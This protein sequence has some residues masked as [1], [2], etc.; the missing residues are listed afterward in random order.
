M[1]KRKSLLEKMRANPRGDWQIKDVETLCEQVG[2]ELRP[3]SGGS[4]FKVCS[5][6]LRDILT[7]PARRPIK[8]PYIRN[9]V[10]YS[11]AHRSLE[12]EGDD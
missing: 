2:L 8:A 10:S 9:L 12:E 6:L 5:P 7:I 11:D 1:R 4:H 3:P